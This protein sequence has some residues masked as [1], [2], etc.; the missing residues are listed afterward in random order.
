MY[1]SNDTLGD[2]AV[3]SG[4]QD[5]FAY[6]LGQ[7]HYETDGFRANNDLKHDL[8]NVFTQYEIS[9]KLNMQA[10]YRH[11]ET[12]HGDLELRGS[13]SN[14][15][16]DRRNLEQNTYRFGLNLKPEK[17][18]NFL[19]SFIYADR[20]EIRDFIFPD[21]T[22]LINEQDKGYQLESQYVLNEKFF[23][24]V[25]GGGT[26]QFDVNRTAQDCVNGECAA[27]IPTD[28]KRNQSFGYLY[29]NINLLANLTTT[30]GVSYD[31]YQSTAPGNN[32]EISQF[33][34]KFG[35]KWNFID[36]F[37][38]RLAAFQSVK[39]PLIVSPNHSADSSGWVQST[40]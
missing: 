1:G 20:N 37:S 26:Y 14:L 18:S 23:N 27:P 32:R 12:E 40:I 33:S 11:R 36:K 35:L 34:P 28:F 5:K 8:Y 25:L 15:T 2:E 19:F 3:F 13:S 29:S 24:A 7:L 39:S 16:Q 10:E 17:R 30:L 6:S 22:N 21:I 38:F 31:S 4:M 9:P